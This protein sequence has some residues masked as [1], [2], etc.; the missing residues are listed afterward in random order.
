MGSRVAGAGKSE[1]GELRD[2]GEG[3]M[4]KSCSTAGRA[5]REVVVR[6]R[7]MRQPALSAFCW[8]PVFGL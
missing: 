2:R 8:K 6:R 1:F 3:V 4:E 7:M 5:G